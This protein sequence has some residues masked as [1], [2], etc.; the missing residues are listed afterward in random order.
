M[1]T[2]YFLL[3]IAG[4]TFSS[5]LLSHTVISLNEFNDYLLIA[6][7]SILL[8]ISAVGV[9]M[10]FDCINDLRKTKLFRTRRRA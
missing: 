3:S 7:Q 9:V 8:I 10:H 4:L 2:C 5:F 6:I 1:K